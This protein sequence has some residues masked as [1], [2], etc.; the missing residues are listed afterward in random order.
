VFEAHDK[1][2]GVG[3][4]VVTVDLGRSSGPNYKLI[5]LR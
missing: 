3:G 1:V 2:H 4:A 5:R